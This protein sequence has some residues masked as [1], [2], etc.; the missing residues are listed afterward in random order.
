MEKLDCAEV[1]LEH[2]AFCVNLFRD[3]TA[4]SVNK[5]EQNRAIFS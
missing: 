1:S 2:P 4:E 5:R 3:K